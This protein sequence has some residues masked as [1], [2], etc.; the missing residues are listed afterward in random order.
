MAYQGFNDNPFWRPP[1]WYGGSNPITGDS[2]DWYRTPFVRDGLSNDLPGGEFERFLTEQGFGGN[3][4]RDQWARNQYNRAQSGYQAA[5]LTN[6]ALTFR[7]Y[8]NT[9]EGGWLDRAFAGLSPQE[10]GAY[11]PSQSKIVRWG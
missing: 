3:T 4:N 11:M 7:R 5:L 2:Q 6:P 10:R 1:N 9:L 8:L